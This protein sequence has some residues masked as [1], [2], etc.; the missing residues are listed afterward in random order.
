[1]MRLKVLYAAGKWKVLAPVNAEGVCEVEDAIQK[2][3]DE[4]KTRAT[5]HGF[6][7]LWARIPSYGPRELGTDKYH[8]VD[9]ANSIY[10]FIKRRHRLLCFEAEGA[11]I[12]CSH[13]FMKTTAKTPTKEK[14]K[15][16]TLRNEY[17]QKSKLGQTRIDE[18]GE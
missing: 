5:G 11:L 12:V 9:D 7:A 13:V 3:I 6:V 10:E 14:A 16:I 17:L 2:L 18:D 1:M 15:A 8:R 4:R